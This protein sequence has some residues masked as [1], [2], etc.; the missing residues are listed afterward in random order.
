VGA[1]SISLFLKKYL[2][3]QQDISGPRHAKELSLVFVC[4]TDLGHEN[5]AEGKKG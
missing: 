3:S 1:K 4:L 5:Q 2:L